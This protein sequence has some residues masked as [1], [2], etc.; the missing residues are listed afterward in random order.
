MGAGFEFGLRANQYTFIPTARMSDYAPARYAVPESQNLEIQSRT[1]VVNHF[2]VENHHV[3]N[4]SIDP[5]EVSAA[6]RTEIRTAEI[7][8]LPRDTSRSP[9]P[10]RS[11]RSRFSAT[12][13]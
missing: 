3:V 2:A 12:P 7:H 13:G 1:A 10:D 5:K 8:E 6:S 4:H 11:P 9:Q